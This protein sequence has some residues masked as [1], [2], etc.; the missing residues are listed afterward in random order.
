MPNYV[1]KNYENGDK[2]EG[3]FKDGKFNGQG[4]YYGAY[5]DKYVGEFKDDNFHGQGTYYWADGAKYVG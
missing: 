1:V 3:Q 2:F 4:T 5:G